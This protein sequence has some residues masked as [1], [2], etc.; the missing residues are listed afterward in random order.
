MKTSEVPGSMPQYLD[1][2]ALLLAI[3]ITSIP[4]HLT[5]AAARY[6]EA[7]KAR[8]YG[9][10]M[11][12]QRLG[13]VRTSMTQSMTINVLLIVKGMQGNLWKAANFLKMMGTSHYIDVFNAS[14]KKG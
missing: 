5:Q 11:S 12:S 7:D 13:P 10:T 6:R 3:A 1:V 9:Q 2:T 4:Q 14:S 8:K